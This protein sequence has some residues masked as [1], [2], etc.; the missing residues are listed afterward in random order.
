MLDRRS[1]AKYAAGVALLYCTLHSVLCQLP[2]TMLL[3][4]LLLQNAENLSP[5]HSQ[6]PNV[7]LLRPTSTKEKESNAMQDANNRE[8]STCSVSEFTPLHHC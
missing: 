4:L 3:L 8:E 5:H 1:A 2:T 7:T 6:W